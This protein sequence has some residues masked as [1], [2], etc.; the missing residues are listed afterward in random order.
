[1]NDLQEKAEKITEE[2]MVVI[3]GIL[4][5]HPLYENYIKVWRAHNQEWKSNINL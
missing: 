3:K 5:W 2:N 1:M 4:H